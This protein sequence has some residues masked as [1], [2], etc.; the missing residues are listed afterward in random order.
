MEKSNSNDSNTNNLI[1]CFICGI[2]FKQFHFVSHY[3]EC[4]ENYVFN[5][6][7]KRQI[8]EPK[9]FDEFLLKIENREDIS[10]ELNEYNNFV[11]SIHF[12]LINK[13]CPNCKQKFY[14]N[15]YLTHAKTCFHRKSLTFEPIQERYQRKRRKMSMEIL[16]SIAKDEVKCFKCFNILRYQ[17]VKPVK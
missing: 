4:K 5:E 12:E 1:Y 3:R 6:N 16:K 2:A 10:K 15:E 9:Q 14:P 8:K 7:N 17:N 11:E 13:E